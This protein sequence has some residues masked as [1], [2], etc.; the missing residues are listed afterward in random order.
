MDE[1]TQTSQSRSFVCWILRESLILCVHAVSQ[2]E[3][4]RL[5]HSGKSPRSVLLIEEQFQ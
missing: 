3:I 4:E 5:S 2:I 1:A